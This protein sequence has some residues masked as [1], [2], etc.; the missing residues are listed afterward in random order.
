MSWHYQ[1]MRHVNEDSSEWYGVHEYYDLS[2]T[3]APSI[4]PI[5]TGEN[6]QDVIWSLQMMLADIEEHGVKDYNE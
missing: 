6:E 5:V 3:P 4:T 1:L 2:G